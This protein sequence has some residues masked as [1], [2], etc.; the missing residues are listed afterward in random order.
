[1]AVSNRRRCIKAVKP[2]EG[3]VLQ[4][5]YISEGRLLLPMDQWLNSIR[6]APLRDPEVWNSATTNGLFIQFR[7]VEIS[8]DELLDMAEYGRDRV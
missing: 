1:M 3:H 7:D 5:D 8:H 6:F 2:L 4:V